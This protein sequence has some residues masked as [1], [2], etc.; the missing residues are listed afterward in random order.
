[1]AISADPYLRGQIKST[2]SI[3]AGGPM[4]G[5]VSGKVII[6]HNSAWQVGDL[7]GATL[8]FSTF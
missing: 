3:K 2:G 1:M 4:S 5:F 7:F 8:P 6:S